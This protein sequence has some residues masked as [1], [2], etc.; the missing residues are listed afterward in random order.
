MLIIFGDKMDKVLS[1]TTQLSTFQCFE[2]Q[3]VTHIREEQ[4]EQLV[5]RHRIVKVEMQKVLEEFKDIFKQPETLPPQRQHDHKINMVEG[6]QL[7]NI[8]PYRYGSL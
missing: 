2:L 5:K 7:I 8:R 6:A 3:L 1:K 4:N